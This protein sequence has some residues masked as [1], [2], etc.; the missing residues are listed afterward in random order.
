M[1]ELIQIIKGDDVK[2]DVSI[3][4]EDLTPY[5][6]SSVTAATAC[7]INADDSSLSLTLGSGVSVLDAVAGKL[8]VSISDTESAL[9]KANEEASFEVQIDE[10]GDKQSF[11]FIESLCIKERI[12]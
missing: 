3:K 12:C 9:L 11:Q 5:D 6:L 10:S 8:R 1:S 7:F 4:N 2:I